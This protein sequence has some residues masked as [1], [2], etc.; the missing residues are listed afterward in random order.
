[1]ERRNLNRCKRIR[2]IGPC[3]NRPSRTALRKEESQRDASPLALTKPGIDPYAIFRLFFQCSN[4]VCRNYTY[5]I[6]TPQLCSETSEEPTSGAPSQS[7]TKSPHITVSVVPPEYGRPADTDQ[8]ANFATSPTKDSAPRIP[9]K[10][11][12]KAKE[13]SDAEKKV[14]RD[15]FLLRNSVAASK[16]RAKR[17][18]FIKD[19]DEAV[20]VGKQKNDE[21]KMERDEFMEEVF[22]LKGMVARCQAEDDGT[23]EA[24]EKQYTQ[25]VQA[26]E[27][28]EDVEEMVQAKGQAEE[29][30]A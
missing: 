2:T 18:D 29:G 20:R 24:L 28:F 4:Q 25:E 3:S 14:V 12:R 30:Q 1:M 19:L 22:V 8:Q 17:K 10:R 5:D 7:P 23:V 27:E 13:R 16:C 21:L 6:P 11:V 26:V 9:K 15:A